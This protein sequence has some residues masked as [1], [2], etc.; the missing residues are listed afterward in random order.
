MKNNKWTDRLPLTDASFTNWLPGN[1]DTGWKTCVMGEW[2][3]AGSS[4][5]HQWE[6]VY[7]TL[8]TN[9]LTLCQDMIGV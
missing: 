7:C 3:P 6:S 8:S 4:N 1:P 5:Q 2:T 9:Y